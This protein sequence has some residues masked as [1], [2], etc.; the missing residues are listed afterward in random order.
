MIV[1]GVQFNRSATILF[2]EKSELLSN[3]SILNWFP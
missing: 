1:G 2:T 3:I